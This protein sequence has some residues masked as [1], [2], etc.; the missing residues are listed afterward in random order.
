ML[1]SRGGIKIASN[2]RSPVHIGEQTAV[3]SSS[4]SPVVGTRET[5]RAKEEEI[6]GEMMLGGRKEYGRN[7]VIKEYEY[8]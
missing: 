8:D 4:S 7:K 6:W 5:E 1:E 2:C 3:S